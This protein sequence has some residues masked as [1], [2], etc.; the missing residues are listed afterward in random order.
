MMNSSFLQIISFK[1]HHLC[2]NTN[3]MAN[4]QLPSL[5]LKEIFRKFV[6]LRTSSKELFEHS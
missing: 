6:P 3:S 5:G 4:K 1:V 2:K